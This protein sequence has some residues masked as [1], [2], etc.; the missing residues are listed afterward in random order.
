[1]SRPVTL[2]D[3]KPSAIVFK[4]HD[5]GCLGWV[6][7]YCRVEGRTPKFVRLT[8]ENGETVRKSLDWA[9]RE[10][11]IPAVGNVDETVLAKLV[12]PN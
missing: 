11:A 5:S 7:Y 2:D 12:K 8:G 10:L 9:L 6:P 1:M 3:L 4:M